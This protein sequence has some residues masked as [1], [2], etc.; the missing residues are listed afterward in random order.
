MGRIVFYKMMKFKL[1]VSAFFILAFQLA[2]S[3]AFCQVDE[4]YYSVIAGPVNVPQY[5]ENPYSPFI[6]GEVPAGQGHSVVCTK[7]TQRL[8]SQY[9]SGHLHQA[10]IQSL[11][12][13]TAVQGKTIC[14]GCRGHYLI[15]IPIYLQTDN[16]RL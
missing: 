10:I 12:R 7:D 5:E 8:L 4:K 14:F 3:S 2:F 16:F 13:T 15:N 9:S 11:R 6:L 1:I